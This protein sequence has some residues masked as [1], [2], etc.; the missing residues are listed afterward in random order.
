MDV[1]AYAWGS[2]EADQGEDASARRATA[3]FWIDAAHSRGRRRSRKGRAASTATAAGRA[4]SY[5]GARDR[6]DDAADR[7]PQ[8]AAGTTTGSAGGAAAAAPAGSRQ[9]R[10]RVHAALQFDDGESGVPSTGGAEST[11]A[12]G[13]AGDAAT[14]AAPPRDAAGKRWSSAVSAA[15]RRAR[16]VHADLPAGR[17]VVGSRSSGAQW[18]A[19]FAAGPGRDAGSTTTGDADSAIASVSAALHADAGRDAANGT[20]SRERDRYDECAQAAGAR[21]DAGSGA[22]GLTASAAAGAGDS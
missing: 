8:G 15:G 7:N 10:G 4:A 20:G 16:R 6:V 21:A 18:T 5:G 17:S 2:C 11:T 9:A 12:T 22:A 1:V 19:L 3:P 14:R 13:S